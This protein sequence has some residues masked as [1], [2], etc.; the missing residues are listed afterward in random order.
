MSDYIAN[1]GFPHYQTENQNTS[2]EKFTFVCYAHRDAEY[3]GKI[4]HAL[5]EKGIHLWYDEGIP[6]GVDWRSHIVDAAIKKSSAMLVFISK[7]LVSSDYCYAEVAAAQTN[8]IV[9]IPIMIEETEI[10]SNLSYALSTT[11]FIIAIQIISKT[12]STT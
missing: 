2:I 9:R 8:G 4:T 7:S 12:Q 1:F 5:Y 3:V 6:E 10:P 11:Q